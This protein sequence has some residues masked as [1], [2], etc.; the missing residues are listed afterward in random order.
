MSAVSVLAGEEA[1]SWRPTGLPGPRL[2]RSWS[3]G[4]TGVAR[5]EGAAVVRIASVI[6]PDVWAVLRERGIP[7]GPVLATVPRRVVEVVVPSGTA[8]VWPALRFTRCVEAPV[9][10]VPAPTVTAASGLYPADGRLWIVPP[11]ATVPATTDAGELAEAVM[12]AL[13]R[14]AVRQIETEPDPA[15]GYSREGQRQ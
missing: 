3:V 13:A 1:E 11:A 7:R 4:W 10:R 15:H 8:E 9:M 14:H 2:R 5:V 6:V 12:A